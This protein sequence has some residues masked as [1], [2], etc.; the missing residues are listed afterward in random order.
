[1]FAAEI[2]TF[3]SAILRRRA[4]RTGFVVGNRTRPGMPCTQFR[5]AVRGFVIS[6]KVG[7]KTYAEV[8]V[9]L[10]DSKIVYGFWK[11]TST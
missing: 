10:A 8:T 6:D 7:G 11:V 4:R 9:A 2:T 3:S 5:L 1:M